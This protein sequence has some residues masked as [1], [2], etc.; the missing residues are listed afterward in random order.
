[1]IE[2]SSYSLSISAAPV[3][4]QA[5]RTGRILYID[6][7]AVPINMQQGHICKCGISISSKIK[8]I[9]V[10]YSVTGPS[11]CGIKFNLSHVIFGCGTYSTAVDPAILEVIFE[12]TSAKIDGSAC[13]KLYFGK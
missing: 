12:K 1:M 10:F 2:F 5:H 13:L 6:T 4:T 11:D 9:N 8:N 3:C 7:S